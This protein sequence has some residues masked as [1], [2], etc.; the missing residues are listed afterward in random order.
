M[1][2]ISKL[3]VLLADIHNLKNAAIVAVNERD[4][5][6]LLNKCKDMKRK[7]DAIEAMLK[8]DRS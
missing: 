2:N 4:E 7:I 6:T 5:G 3:R 1:K 8:E